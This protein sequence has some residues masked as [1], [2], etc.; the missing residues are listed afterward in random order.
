MT[1][2]INTDPDNPL[3]VFLQEQ[4][5]M[6]GA[7]EALPASRIWQFLSGAVQE[8]QRSMIADEVAGLMQLDTLERMRSQ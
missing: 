3:R 2:F 7:Q 4:M 1:F 8:M 5:H 6:T